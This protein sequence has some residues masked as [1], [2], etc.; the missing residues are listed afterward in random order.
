MGY[1]SRENV[2]PDASVQIPTSTTNFECD[3][4]AG[5]VWDDNYEYDNH[6][7]NSYG[8]GSGF[9]DDRSV[10]SE[11]S[12]RQ[13][14]MLSGKGYLISKNSARHGLSRDSK[15]MVGS[16]PGHYLLNRNNNGIRFN[17]EMYMTKNKPGT[18][19]RHA[20][21][22]IRERNMRTGRRDEDAYFKVAY[23]IGECC[24]DRYGNLFYNSPEEYE[25]H[26]HTVVSQQI[27]KNW[28]NRNMEYQKQIMK[29]NMNYETGYK[30]ET[31]GL[32]H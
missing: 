5:E 25:R 16:E 12:N 30:T 29:E 17:I 26:F 1:I 20:V 22:G 9:H 10:L 15:G 14:S 8:G 2:V 21:S 28:L 31:Y 7:I 19:I 23:S 24:Q 6:S 18:I 4:V 32:I 27:K 11:M 13:N 3:K